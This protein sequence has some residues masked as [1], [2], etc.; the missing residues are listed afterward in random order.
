M[1]ACKQVVEDL[2]HFHKHSVG[3][4]EAEPEVCQFPNQQRPM[5][6]NRVIRGKWRPALVLNPDA[7]GAWQQHLQVEQR[8]IS[9]FMNDGHEQL[10]LDPHRRSKEISS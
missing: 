2:A 8:R 9:V 3:V 5:T 10:N 6:S 7:K 4:P 1:E